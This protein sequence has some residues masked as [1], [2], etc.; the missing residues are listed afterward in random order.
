VAER[1]AL[2]NGKMKNEIQDN[3]EKIEEQ[4]AAKILQA[5]AH[6]IHICLGAIL[7]KELYDLAAADNQIQRCADWAKKQG[8]EWVEGP[9]E[10]QLRKGPLIVARFR[11]MLQGEGENT[12][13][14]FYANVMGKAVSVTDMNPLMN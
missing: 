4:F 10:T 13:C 2:A 11:P 1:A 5:K 6:F 3:I 8:Y 7:P 12:K 9:G 14:V